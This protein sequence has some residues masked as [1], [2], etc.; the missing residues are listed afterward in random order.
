MNSIGRTLF[1]H[2]EKVLAGV[3]AL[4]LIYSVVWYGPWTYQTQHETMLDEM[5]FKLKT[6]RPEL[7]EK[8]VP[9]K[10]A[11]AANFDSIGKVE[12]QV[13]IEKSVMWERL[14]LDPTGF[15]VLPPI[16][17]SLEA[18]RGLI[19]VRWDLNPNQPKPEGKLT[20]VGAEVA[21]APVVAGHVGEY[22]SVTEAGGKPYLSPAAL[23]ELAEAVGSEITA[24]GRTEV[25]GPRRGRGAIGLTVEDVMGAVAA[26]DITFTEAN[27]FVVRAVQDGRMSAQ[28]RLTFNEIRRMIPMAR[29]GVRRDLRAE[30]RRA[31]TDEEINRRLFPELGISADPT[32]WREYHTR[33]LVR[34]AQVES[35]KAKTVKRTV[36]FG[37]VAM[38]A[39]N[40]VS[41]DLEYQYR[42]RFWAQYE[43][44]VGTEVIERDSE[45]AVVAGSVAPKADT[46]FIL[47]GG[48]VDDGRPWIRVRK[49]FASVDGWISRDYHV[50]PGEKI[51]RTEVFAK[52]DAQGRAVVDEN[53]QAV[54]EEVDFSTECV[55]LS[56]DSKPKVGGLGVENGGASL[57]PMLQIVYANRRGELRRKWQE[58]LE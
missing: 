44:P 47:T 16:D 13:A 33:Q 57:Y 48:S 24:K 14:P 45:W 15:E 34:S 28:V 7:T 29:P 22:E 54:M 55:L 11:Y 38:F 39:D 27:R 8:D 18:L 46:E 50:S 53:R 31:P 52:R 56:F 32:K 10:P 26:G 9:D 5:I 42:V 12:P 35:R 3:F 37:E 58:S 23:Y 1:L 36:R 43:P 20:F 6:E 40:S 17:L 30:L 41:P 49:W 51:G 2:F 19:V 21:R 25:R 4:V